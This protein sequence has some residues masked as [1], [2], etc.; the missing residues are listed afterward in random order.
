MNIKLYDPALTTLV[1]SYIDINLHDDIIV[2]KLIRL[3]SDQ[4]YD[5]LDDIEFTT[6]PNIYKLLQKL[7]AN[8]KNNDYTNAIFRLFTKKVTIIDDI[9]EELLNEIIDEIYVDSDPDMIVSLS[10]FYNIFSKSIDNIYD[11]LQQLHY[12]Q[13]I[14]FVDE[15]DNFNKLQ[16]LLELFYMNMTMTIN[17]LSIKEFLELFHDYKSQIVINHRSLL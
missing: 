7:L 14:N 13:D 12:E 11:E 1:H 9:D 10:T 4:I 8:N 2:N 16:V 17:K 5:Y 6:Y 3:K 15:S